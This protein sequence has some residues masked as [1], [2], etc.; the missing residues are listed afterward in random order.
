VPVVK[1]RL[2]LLILAFVPPVCRAGDSWPQFRGPDGQGHADA[3]A[4]P[5]TWSETN[6]I[7]WKTSIVGRGWSSP[8]I[9]GEMIW[10]TT[11]LD[12][13]R[14][15]YAVC[16]DRG[17]GA[18]LR[19]IKVF[20]VD[21]PE[22]INA[23]NSYASPTPVIEAGRVWVHFGTYGTA[24]LDISTGRILWRN[25]SLRLDHKEGPGSS[26]ILVGNLLVVN[27][28][29]MDVQYVAAL[30][31]NT[32]EVVWKAN[33]TG[34]K[35]PDPDLRKAYST[36]LAIEVDRQRQIVSVGA[37]RASAYD[38]ASGDELWFVDFL[39][40]SNVPRPIFADGL[41][42]LD[43]GYMKPEL[44]AVRPDGYGDVTKTHAAWHVT[45][46]VPA[47]P[48]P[49]AVGQELFMV[50]DQG[51]L[52]CLDVSS[53]KE[54]F[55][56]RLGGN[57]TASPIAAGRRIYFCSEEGETAVIESGPKFRELARNK[58]KGRI[59]ASPAVAGDA[60]FLR[61]D[62]HLYRI[63]QKRNDGAAAQ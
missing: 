20:D 30:D 45:A 42:I 31:K 59:M 24:C 11:A 32:G 47:N 63:E 14:S 18:I 57:Y 6:N 37:N 55:K 46:Q 27:C 33:R 7:A 17:T 48:S 39:G 16:I 8:V 21:R 12:G 61:T 38:A 22:K 23:K 60:M 13:G 34:H 53:G 28:D 52:S 10:L 15:L 29:G 41:V 9:E 36:P 58:L 43:T 3:T 35:D 5:I 54:R 44:F 56:S 51:V 50:S 2:V 62:T 19:E 1:S 40:F 49:V 4:L 26:P 25:Q